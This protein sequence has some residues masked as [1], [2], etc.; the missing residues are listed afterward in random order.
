MK[1]QLNNLEAMERRELRVRKT[2]STH[3]AIRRAKRLCPDCGG[4]CTAIMQA[5]QRSMK[6]GTL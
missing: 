2:N 3:R 6:G 1:A 4:N 5:I